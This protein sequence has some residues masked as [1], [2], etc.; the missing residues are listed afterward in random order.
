VLCDIGLT[1]AGGATVLG[2]FYSAAPGRTSAGP[3]SDTGR[4]RK[5]RGLG[6][7]YTPLGISSHD[8]QRAAVSIESEELQMDSR[9]IRHQP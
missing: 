4:R 1:P 2:R 6:S 5:T 8:A 3:Q 7:A 9:F